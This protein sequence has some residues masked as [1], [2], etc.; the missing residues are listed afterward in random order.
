MKQLRHQESRTANLQNLTSNP[1][2]LLPKPV[3][4]FQLSQWDLIIMPLIMVMLISTFQSFQLN[5]IMSIF[6]IQTPLQLNQFMM[7]KWTIYCNSSTQNMI[8]TFWLLNYICFRIYWFSPLLQNF[9]QYIL[10]C[11][12]NTE[13][14]ML[15]SKIAC[16]NFICL[17]QPRPM[18]NWL[19][20]TQY[21][22]K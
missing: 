7:M 21:M 8:M 18:W 5:L 16:Q 4:G 9:I 13:E 6:Q 17:S 22:P 10:C 3:M 15:Q 11:F 14:K 2:P 12:I 19:M 20:E 1:G